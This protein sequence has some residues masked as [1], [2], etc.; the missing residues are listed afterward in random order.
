LEW[1]VLVIGGGI[2]GASIG[3]E[4]AAGARVGLLEM[5]PTLGYHTTGRSAATW[6]ETYGNSTVRA[7]TSA[8]R[9]F[10]VHPPDTF[11]PPLAAP[12]PLLYIAGEG[13]G[14]A[15]DALHAEVSDR[16]SDARILDGPE[17]ERVNA[18]LRPGCV[19]RAMLEPGALE[20]NVHELHQGYCRGLRRRGGTTLA[21]ARVTSARRLGDRW[22]VV[23]A[24]GRRFR[25]RVVVNAAGAW[26][27]LVAT[28]FG[29]APVG[30]APLRRS[31]FVVAAPAY[32]RAHMPLT[33]DIDDRFYVKPE[34]VQFLCSPADETLQEPGDARP[35]EVEIARAID[36]INAVMRLDI[37]HVRRAWAGLRSF[38]PD[39]TPVVGFD[40]AVDGL[41]WYAGQGGYGIQLCPAM[42]RTG[43]ALISGRPVP[44]DVLDR[45]LDVAAL[46]ARTR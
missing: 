37:R 14:E 7:L 23:D 1:D 35:D 33:V 3:Y 15:I 41:F 11:K 38:T 12:L 24:N 16:T 42:A 45:G 29:A 27:D 9:A 8:S 30:I 39:R 32:E 28:V 43:A 5:E 31:V 22:E 25:A 2:A 40:P 13:R 44:R 17:A 34:G 6:L 26:C 20:V 19:E 4:I 10:L 36:D 21:S 18:L 46:G